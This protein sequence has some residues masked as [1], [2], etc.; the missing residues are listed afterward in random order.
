MRL[1]IICVILTASTLSA[2]GKD[3]GSGSPGGE[4]KSPPPAPARGAAFA[5]CPNFSGRYQNVSGPVDIEQKDCSAVTFA[6]VNGDSH[7]LGSTLEVGGDW[8]P[9]PNN[10]TWVEKSEWRGNT[11][12]FTSRYNDEA[13]AQ[14][15]KNGDDSIDTLQVTEFSANPDKGLHLEHRR[16]GI[17]GQEVQKKE[18]GT[19]DLKPLN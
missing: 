4:A 2:C 12:V 11:L 19:F 18:W 13:L 3:S 5:G 6:P 14:S 15:Q 10:S 16:Y 7:G 8:K 17:H 9:R 1:H